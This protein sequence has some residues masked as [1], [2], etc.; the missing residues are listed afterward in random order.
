MLNSKSL[1]Q[2]VLF[3]LGVQWGVHSHWFRKVIDLWLKFTKGPGPRHMFCVP[4]E[5]IMPFMYPVI[6]LTKG[7][8]TLITL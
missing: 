8:V 6:T 4:C 7:Y 3:L 1:Q 5:V 2:Q